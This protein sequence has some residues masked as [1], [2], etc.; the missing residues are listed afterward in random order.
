MVICFIAL[1]VFAVLGIFSLKYR[2]LAGEAFD[3][4]LRRVTFRPC[5]SRL[6]E[7]IKAKIVS[8]VLPKN[9]ALARFINRN[10][11]LLS[12]LLVIATFA[13]LFFSLQ[14]IY[15]FFLYGNCNGPSGGFCIYRGVADTIACNNTTVVPGK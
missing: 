9:P 11:E 3:C 8:K 15:N 2:N 1:G 6:D 10:F 4:V 14:G 5:T 12:W 7:R 13:S